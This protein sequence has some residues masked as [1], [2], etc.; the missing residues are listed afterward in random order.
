MSSE[1][2]AAEL[3]IRLNCNMKCD[4]FFKFVQSEP[5]LIK[6]ARRSEKYSFKRKCCPT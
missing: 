6:Y 4:D 2:I 5:D 3:K 1:A